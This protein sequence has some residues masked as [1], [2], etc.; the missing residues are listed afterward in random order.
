MPARAR[1][2]AG[3]TL[4]RPACR[5]ILMQGRAQTYACALAPVAL[6]AR[7]RVMRW[8]AHGP[9]RGARG[10]RGPEGAPVA[11]AGPGVDLAQG[12]SAAAPAG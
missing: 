9:S 12:G 1:Q 3:T 8:R 6:V 4:V 2:C 7:R 10:G 11:R 5:P